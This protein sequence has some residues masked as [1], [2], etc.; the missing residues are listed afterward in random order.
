MVYNTS[1]LKPSQLPTSAM[2]LADPKWK[3]KIAS[4]PGRPTFSPS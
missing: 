4:P 2:E 3:G 1:L